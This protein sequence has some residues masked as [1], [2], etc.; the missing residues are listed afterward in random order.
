MT[1]HSSTSSS[2]SSTS[3]TTSSSSSS[4]TSTTTS[5]SSSSSTTT[6]STTSTTSSSSS[7]H[8]KPANWCKA[9]SP[10]GRRENGGCCYLLWTTQ[11]QQKI[12]SAS[13]ANPTSWCWSALSPLRPEYTVSYVA[14]SV[15]FFN[16]GLS[17]KSEELTNAVLHVRLHL[18]VQSFT[19]I[20]FPLAVW[21]LVKLLALMAVN[22]WLLK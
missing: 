1:S 3:S 17:L 13:A 10:G 21:L 20:F 19:L 5:T 22:Q 15:I 11:Q 12:R 9:A 14:V 6:T 7:P 18:L 2:S 8:P 4:T 16:S